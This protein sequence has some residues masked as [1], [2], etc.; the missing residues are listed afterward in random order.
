MTD[1]N[2]EKRYVFPESQLKAFLSDYCEVVFDAAQEEGLQKL[3]AELIKEGK[4]W[5]DHSDDWVEPCGED[6]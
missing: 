2:E 3:L 1:D 5:E 4:I 6:R